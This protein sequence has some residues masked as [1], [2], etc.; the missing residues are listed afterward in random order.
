MLNYKFLLPILLLVTG[1]AAAQSS[2]AQ[3]E[4]LKPD[5]SLNIY[6]YIDDCVAIGQRLRFQYRIK[7]DSARYAIPLQGH[8]AYADDVSIANSTVQK[9]MQQFNGDQIAIAPDSNVFRFKSMPWILGYAIAGRYDEV[10]N[11]IAQELQYIPVDS[12]SEL[13]AGYVDGLSKLL[14]NNIRPLNY[15]IIDSLLE[16]VYTA[17]YP[18]E[19]DVNAY[20]SYLVALANYMNNKW[21]HWD[22][23]GAMALAS[24]IKLIVDSVGFTEE[25][26]E[27]LV[28]HNVYQFPEVVMRYNEVIN[29]F[30]QLDTLRVNGPE[31]YISIRQQSHQKAL[32]V[33]ADHFPLYVGHPAEP[34]TPNRFIPLSSTSQNAMD[35]VI[36]RPGRMSFMVF[37]RDGCRIEGQSGHEDMRPYQ[38]SQCWAAYGVLRRVKKAFPQLDVTVV[39]QTLGVFGSKL[40]IDSLEEIKAIQSQ[41]HS[42]HNLPVNLAIVYTGYWRLP[43]PDSRRIDIDP[44]YVDAYFGYPMYPMGTPGHQIAYVISPDRKIL[45]KAGLDQYAERELMEFLEAAMAWYDN[46]SSGPVPTFETSALDGKDE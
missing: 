28:G 35:S 24:R 31:S 8:A 42:F 44:P 10:A 29:Y 5:T 13:I 2:Q 26:L 1:S 27:G 6:T 7:Q 12:V 30:G 39:T 36:P 45:S 32:G 17:L 43:P 33:F 9:C 15:G 4:V 37:L 34:I 22:R 16:P 20:A 46:G 14:T 38:R 18:R 40:M 41:W 3:F 25:E 23:D 19:R 21:T 11:L